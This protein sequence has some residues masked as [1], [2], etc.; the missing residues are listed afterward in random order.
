[1]KWND[2]LEE[3]I[4]S[5]LKIR[6]LKTLIESTRPLTGIK[7]AQAA[8]YSHTQTYK[9]L[10]DLEALGIITKDYAG[11]S[12]LYSINRGNYIVKYIVTPSIEAERKMLEE[13]A[14]RFYERIGE[15]L[16]SLTLYGSV[17][18]G[19]DDCGSDIDLILVTR[20]A[21]DVEALEDVAAEVSLETALEFGGPVSAFVVSE[22]EYR[23]RLAAGRAMWAGVKAE[24]QTIPRKDRAEARVG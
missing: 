10:D 22:T 6:V 9:A 18:R 3:A 17:A 8:G 2:T 15:D 13:F 19:D 7:I 5:R 11:A 23:R 16:L 24:G 12:N 4:G 20:D 1:M 14:S 21:A